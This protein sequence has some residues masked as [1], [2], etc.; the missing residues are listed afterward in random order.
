MI[1]MPVE[2]YTDGSSLRNPGESG[3]GYIIQYWENPE[4]DDAMPVSKRIEG[5]QGFRRSTNNRM[6]IMAAIYGIRAI[7]EN[8]N[9]VLQGITQINLYS[10][11]DYLV[12]AITQRWVEKWMRS[13][14]MTSGFGGSKPKAVKNR[15]LWE[16]LLKLQDQLKASSINLTVTHVTG[17]AG[18]E[19]N[20]LADRLAVK[21]SNDA[22]HHIIDE[23]YENSSG[24]H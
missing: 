8:Q 3:L 21:A 15:D 16:E 23:A 2:L 11:S 4:N 7:L 24:K 22:V 19:L 9:G 13:N 10:D 18:N 17:H 6:E 20:E 1:T 14:W 5:S 12:K